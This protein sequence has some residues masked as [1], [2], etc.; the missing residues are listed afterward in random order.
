MQQLHQDTTTVT[1][2]GEYQDQAPAQQRDRPARITRGYN[3]DHRPDLK[4]LLYNR[5]ITADGAVPVH[6]R[7]M[8]A[9]PLMIRVHAQTWLALVGIIG[10]SDFLYVAD[11]KLCNR[12]DRA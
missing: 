4:Q 3:K 11:S 6:C 12:E 2:C 7:S 1:F 8:T 9:T 5:T 10:S